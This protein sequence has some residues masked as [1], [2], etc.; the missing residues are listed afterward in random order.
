MASK[1]NQQGTI[2]RAA[3]AGQGEAKKQTLKDLVERMLPQIAKALPKVIT[4][5]RFARIALTALSSTP[6][7]M[8]CEPK[9]FLGAL[10]QAAQLGLEPN[11][12]LGQAYL[13][14]FRNGAKKIV[15]CQFQVGYKGLLALAYR[16]GEMQSVQAH[17]VYENDV[18]E[19]E[20]GLEPILRHVPAEADRGKPRCYY[21]VFRLKNGGYGFEVMSVED[22]KNHSE[23][24]SFPVKM[25]KKTP[26]ADPDLFDEMAKKTV[27]KKALKY[28]PLNTEFMAAAASDEK[29]VRVASEDDLNL[30]AGE[31]EAEPPAVDMETGEMLDGEEN[32]ADGKG[33][34]PLFGQ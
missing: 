25:G 15:E 21:A 2:E 31:P 4:P 33:D 9:S 34:A 30:L 19:Y 32:A 18:F 11:T 23:R 12:P 1:V 28:A 26:W 20:L 5:E 3:A 16:G 29:V 13:I 17:C 14:P 10:M 22:V 24:F 7:L 8:E 6:Q 27:I